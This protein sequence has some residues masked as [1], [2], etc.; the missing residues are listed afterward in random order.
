MEN[1]Q[2][3]PQTCRRRTEESSPSSSDQEIWLCLF[4]SQKRANP[5]LCKSQPVPKYSCPT[6]RWGSLPADLGCWQ[7][8]GGRKLSAPCPCV[9]I[10]SP[11]QLK[12]DQYYSFFSCWLPS[13]SWIW[14]LVHESEEGGAGRGWGNTCAVSE[15]RFLSWTQTWVA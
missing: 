4:N 15:P 1:T 12:W 8:P 10:M 13:D 11:F 2:G 7:V 3:S 6:H 14:K 9:A 5:L